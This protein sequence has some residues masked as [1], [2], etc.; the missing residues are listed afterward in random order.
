MQQTSRRRVVGALGMLGALGALGALGI[1]G[2]RGRV[3]RTDRRAERPDPT[4]WAQPGPYRTPAGFT[5]FDVVRT[6]SFGPRQRVALTYFFYWYDSAFMRATRGTTAT[7]RFNPANHETMSFRDPQWYVQEFTDMQAAGLDAALPVYWGEP[8][9]WNRRVA[10][11]PALN[12]FATEGLAP[13]V[14]ALDTLR[15]RGRPF[16]VGLFF[17]DRK[18]VV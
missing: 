16:K 8:G 2:A 5:G 13:M 3:P 11:A 7:Y 15:G 1:V 14:E 6:Q 4:P 10:P 9:Q 12:L 17:E 18:S